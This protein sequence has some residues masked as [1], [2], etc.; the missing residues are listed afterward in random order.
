MGRPVLCGGQKEKERE[1]ERA[2]ERLE[3]PEAPK[4]HPISVNAVITSV[5]SS[6]TSTSPFAN[7]ADG[8]KSLRR[9]RVQEIT[10]IPM[11]T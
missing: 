5:L 8:R 3:A 10:T 4:G 11:S 2:R 6:K 1:R 7:R 9:I